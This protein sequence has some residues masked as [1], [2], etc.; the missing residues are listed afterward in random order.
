[1]AQKGVPSPG[2]VIEHLEHARGASS[3][4]R[5][6]HG[7]NTRRGL[8]GAHHRA[9]MDRRRSA[10]QGREAILGAGSKNGR[11]VPGVCSVGS[12]ADR[13]RYAWISSGV[14]GGSTAPRDALEHVERQA[15]LRSASIAASTRRARPKCA[16]RAPSGV[17]DREACSRR[18]GRE[19]GFD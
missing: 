17:S 12:R 15:Q 13:Q 6:R 5:A 1:M 7:L 19:E 8:R 3:E 14:A 2:R 9:V 4:F 11:R 16:P 18:E 10:S